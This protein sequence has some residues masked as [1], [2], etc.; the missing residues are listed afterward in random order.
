MYHYIEAEQLGLV[1]TWTR[2]C[3]PKHNIE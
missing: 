1:W 2:L 3:H